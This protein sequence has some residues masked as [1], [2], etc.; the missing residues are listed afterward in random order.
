MR[1]LNETDI[2]ILGFPSGVQ[3]MLQ[4]LRETIK[5]AAPDAEE[6]TSYRMP[7]YKLNGILVYFAGYK[8]HIGFYPA[9]NGIEA[10]RSE[11]SE[12]KCSKGTIQFALDKPL[13]VE[14]IT[15]IVKFRVS[16]NLAKTKKRAVSG[17]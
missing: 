8:N 3:E 10:F 1:Q 5:N 15:R 16:E 2:Y 14:L 13:P 4:E 9:S 11:L 12:F 7:A 6:V 17:S